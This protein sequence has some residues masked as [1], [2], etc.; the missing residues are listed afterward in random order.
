MPMTRVMGVFQVVATVCL[1]RGR[2][3]SARQGSC[4]QGAM[5]RSLFSKE[6]DKEETLPKTS[7]EKEGTV[8]DG[9]VVRPVTFSSDRTA[10]NRNS[11]DM[12]LTCHSKTCVTGKISLLESHTMRKFSYSGE[13]REK[14][15]AGADVEMIVYAL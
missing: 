4:S 14:M 3:Q 7:R 12:C 8:Y 15:R 5:A 6:K 9:A 11:L 1:S 2:A 10:L 13:F